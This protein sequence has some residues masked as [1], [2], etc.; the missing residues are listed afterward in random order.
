MDQ[1]HPS[2][3]KNKKTALPSVQGRFAISRLPVNIQEINDERERN[4]GM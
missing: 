4:S 3:V 2:V 1:F